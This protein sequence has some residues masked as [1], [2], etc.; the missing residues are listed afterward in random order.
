[1]SIGRSRIAPAPT[2]QS[3]CVR[4]CCLDDQ[5]IC[6]GCGRALQEIVQW[7]TASP[8]RRQEILQAAA[9]RRHSAAEKRAQAHT[10]YR[11]KP[12]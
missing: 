2:L 12:D 7:G 11:Q 3:P 5:D 8:E 10:G 1:M 6:L 4:N 9:A